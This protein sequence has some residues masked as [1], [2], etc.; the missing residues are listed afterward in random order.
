[1]VLRRLCLL[2]LV[3]CVVVCHAQNKPKAEDPATK[4]GKTIEQ[5]EDWD[6]KNSFAA[7]AVLFVGSSSIKLWPTAEDFGEFP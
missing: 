2:I 4:W 7:D 1:M 3:C 5:F 6:R